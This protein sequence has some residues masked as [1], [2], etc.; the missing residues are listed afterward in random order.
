MSLSTVSV[1]D[2][3]TEIHRH[4]NSP[5]LRGLLEELRTRTIDLREFCSRVRQVLGPDVLLR[6]VEG[7]QKAQRAKAG[8]GV[9][10]AAP[11]APGAAGAVARPP[12]PPAPAPQ[13]PASAAAQ[14]AAE[15]AARLPP[16]PAPPVAPLPSSLQAPLSAPPA[17]LPLPAPQVAVPP[18]APPTLHVKTEAT[19]PTLLA[20]T[21][22]LPNHA[23]S[24][25][26]SPSAAPSQAIVPAAAQ[27]APN[28]AE[29]SSAAISLAAKGSETN[30]GMKVLI[31]ALLCPK[32]PNCQVDGCA[33]M[34]TVLGKVEAHTR[35]CSIS[36]LAGGQD[37]CTTC[38][39]WQS[40][41]TLREHYRRKLIHYI[42]KTYPKEP[43]VE[44]VPGALPP[45]GPV[46]STASTGGLPLPLPST[47][48][49]QPAT[50]TLAASSLPSVP[51]APAA[52]PSSTSANESSNLTGSNLTGL[53]AAFKPSS[54]EQH[55]PAKRTSSGTGKPVSGKPRKPGPASGK[56]PALTSAPAPP[57]TPKLELPPL[58]AAGTDPQPEG[59]WAEHQKKAFSQLLPAPPLAHQ[60]SD[61]L[62]LVGK[63]EQDPMVGSI[64]IGSY[65]LADDDDDGAL[66][67]LLA[68]ELDERDSRLET[69]NSTAAS[70][71][72]T[73]PVEKK[74]PLP[75]SEFDDLGG[76][77]L[78]DVADA[79]CDWDDDALGNEGG[80]TGMVADDGPEGRGVPAD[81][82]RV[83]RGKPN[84][85]PP[86]K[87]Q[88]T[89]PEPASR[90]AGRKPTQ[91]AYGQTDQ[92]LAG[93]PK[94]PSGGAKPAVHSRSGRK[95]KAT[96]RKMAAIDEQS[97]DATSETDGVDLCQLEDAS[98]ENKMF[99]LIE[100]GSKLPITNEPRED[101]NEV[102]NGMNVVVN[103]CAVPLNEGGKEPTEE[104]PIET[105]KRP[106]PSNAGRVSV[107]H[108]DGTCDV[109]L[110]CNCAAGWCPDRT[111][112]EKL[113]AEKCSERQRCGAGQVIQSVDRAQR[114]ICCSGC[115]SVNIQMALPALR[116]SGC[117][118]AVKTDATYYRENG[119]RLNICSTC[120]N[121][122]QH[123]QQPQYLKDVE[124]QSHVFEKRTWK[125]KETQDLDRY[126]ACDGG[127]DRWF[128]YICARY[129]DPAQLPAEWKLDK[130]KF[131]C[132]DC[133]RKGAKIDQ[134]TRLLALQYR[135]ASSSLHTHPLSDAIEASMAA[136]LKKSGISVHG[137]TVRVVSSKQYKYPAV[138]AMKTRYGSD[139]PDDFPY[140]SRCII[141]FQEVEGKD[142][143]VFAMYVQEYGPACPQPNTN[144]TY[145]SYLDS[146][147]YLVTEPQGSR[148]AVYHAIVNAYLRN[149]RDRGFEHAHIWVAPPQAGDEYIFHQR[150][151]DPR[152]GT[153]PMSMTKLRE[154]YE[155]ML[156]TA[157][158]DGIVTSYQDIQA[159]PRSHA[160]HTRSG[161]IACGVHLAY[162][163]APTLEDGCPRMGHVPL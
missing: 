163:Q 151:V 16:A 14:P 35:S 25:R 33:M 32:K 148:T 2:L 38:K 69:S 117:D 62:L 8:P 84:P 70:N 24:S 13:R 31:H 65:G 77:E 30:L 4:S 127:C 68:V 82:T 160:M 59:G 89:E 87:Y 63:M 106:M 139:Y 91:S 42:Q 21:E 79:F 5:L 36:N 130:Q 64:N 85:Q 90:Q 104:A 152:H 23:V 154:W 124:L 100:T 115:L 34:K 111:M 137:L 45:S 136:T 12:K 54:S 150:P 88:R 97:S 145:I 156:D 110:V 161:A 46:N 93:K 1:E 105:S 39:K 122:M 40:M 157:I 129:P 48:A 95:L 126:V 51:A 11:A 153:K 147:R 149:A 83:S 47:A 6:T 53:F 114:Q 50:E 52:T 26:P 123:G 41:I 138:A 141:A 108:S 128:H 144:R 101:D 119:L 142:V 72:Y 96:E 9:P 81:G 75:S 98:N 37:D 73:A 158:G 57:S 60:Q 135:R 107:V 29:S 92:Q 113:G 132:V 67:R 80:S 112:R 162:E 159:R 121:D 143:A 76:D 155:K 44:P 55:V 140:D 3:S 134:S 118:K 131:I 7:L 18:S 49:R 66:E 58:T 10:R 28:G 61:S 86:H 103:I 20:K 133:V 99:S 27:A 43:G 94:K 109:Q 17:P 56:S 146:V 78:G 15:P 74:R 116:C 125:P 120:H 71:S 19:P 102:K 22:A